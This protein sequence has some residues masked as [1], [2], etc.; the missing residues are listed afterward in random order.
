MTEEQLMREDVA[1]IEDRL[2]GLYEE[3]ENED[4]SEEERRRLV[5]ELDEI[6]Q[7]RDELVMKLGMY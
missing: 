2:V 4:L 6:D 5:A 1:A 7:R 3:L